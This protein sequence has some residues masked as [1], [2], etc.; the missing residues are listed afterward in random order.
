SVYEHGSFTAAAEDLGYAQPTISEQIRSLERSYGVD[1]F[2]RVGRGVAPTSAG[3]A[4]RPLAE[5]TLGAADQAQ[6]AVTSVRALESGTVRFGVFGTARL[7][8]GAQL[9]ADMLERHPGVRVELIG[10]NSTQVE[11]HLR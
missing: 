8:M 1:L 3:E 11:E 4:L 10:Q 6:R 5:L 2:T 7:Y 9:V